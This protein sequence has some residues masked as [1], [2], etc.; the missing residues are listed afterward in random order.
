MKSQISSR[1][2]FSIV[3]SRWPPSMGPINSILQVTHLVMSFCRNMPSIMEMS[4]I[5]LFIT[6]APIMKFVSILYLFIYLYKKALLCY[7]L[8]RSL[9]A[10]QFLSDPCFKHWIPS[11]IGTSYIRSKFVLVLVLFYL[12]L[13]FSPTYINRILYY[14]RPHSHTY[15]H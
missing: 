13:F 6:T 7:N 8:F 2:I 4:M 11:F 14:C 9:L 10:S 3:C 1:C 12:L 15:V 5:S